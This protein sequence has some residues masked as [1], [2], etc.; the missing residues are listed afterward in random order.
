MQQDVSYKVGVGGRLS[1]RDGVFDSLFRAKVGVPFQD[2]SLYLRAIP[3]LLDADLVLKICKEVLRKSCQPHQPAELPCVIHQPHWLHLFLTV[4]IVV[5]QAV[6]NLSSAA[7]IENS[8]CLGQ[9]RFAHTN[10]IQWT[11]QE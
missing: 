2:C 3:E 5:L 8:I 4:L 7:Q 9:E 11:E 10:M 6:L 1:R